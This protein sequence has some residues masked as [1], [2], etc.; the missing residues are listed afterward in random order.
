LDEP[1]FSST[2]VWWS[3]REVEELKRAK[4]GFENKLCPQQVSTDIGKGNNILPNP[5]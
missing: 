4:V 5:I 3:R 1:S 2:S